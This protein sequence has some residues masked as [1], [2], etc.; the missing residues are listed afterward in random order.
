MNGFVLLAYHNSI[1]DQVTISELEIEIERRKIR[2]MKRNFNS[3]V[4]DNIIGY[5]LLKDKDNTE[6]IDS[7]H[8]IAGDIYGVFN[9]LNQ[10]LLNYPEAIQLINKSN[11]ANEYASF[12]GNI[13]ICSIFEN[14]IVVQNDLE[15]YR[16]I[17]YYYDDNILCIST[18]L[19]LILKAI[20]KN[21][22]LRRNAVNIFVCSRESKWPLTFIED[23]LTLSPIS[24]AE[25]SKAG[26][27]ITSKTFSDFYE[28]KNIS[29]ND[30]RE[31]L[32]NQYKLVAQR[33]VGANTAVALS[34]GYDSNCLTKLYSNIYKNNFT[35][36]SVG[37]EAERERDTNINNETIYAEKVA[38]KL[39]IPFKRYFFSRI[40]FFNELD[41]FIDAIDQP[42]HD[43]SSN[44]I[45]N[46]YLQSDGFDLLVHGMGGDA[47]YSSNK[48]FAFVLKLY[49]LYQIFGNE[50]FKF[51]S[52]C[53]NNR[54]PFRYF[55]F[56]S[57]DKNKSSFFDL[58]ERIQLFRSP[59]SKYLDISKQIE[60]DDERR[61]RE[62][63]FSKLYNDSPVYQEIF[64]SLA[65][66]SSPDEY[67][68][69]S[70]AERNNIEILMPFVNTKAALIMMNG[71]YFNKVNNRAFEM[72]VFG[73]LDKE[74]LVKSKSG[75]SIPYSEWLP[76]LAKSIF[77]FYYDLEYFKSEDFNI[78]AF[79][80]KYQTDEAFSKSN[81]A[82]KVLW[83]LLVVKAFT[84]KHHLSLQ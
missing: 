82:N 26:I 27:N 35:A 64:Y 33:K 25:I 56:N 29:K 69:L 59:I 76:P 16:K 36:I 68:A 12:E 1:V 74:L 15:G 4:Y 51:F 40:D 52:K 72:R 61:L 30:L 41:G 45:M 42:G 67:H 24:R 60:I 32:Y 39:K 57:Y 71:S 34:G 81:M 28:L 22:I 20:R 63:F 11:N 8:L 13:C 38:Q 54:G 65:L 37:Y 46:K 47:N 3:L 19:P 5:Q 55:Q 48:N 43:P 31:S 58:F 66:F 7:N 77:E 14:K 83:K 78:E 50:F 80:S 49:Q 79:K 44:Y 17:F 62:F 9:E 75:F 70:M 6:V 18:Y 53:F 84:Q 23:V 21:W 73:G 2:F 10:K